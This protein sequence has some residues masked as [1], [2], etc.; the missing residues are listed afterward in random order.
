MNATFVLIL[1]LVI[2]C[3]FILVIATVIVSN[4][5]LH[6]KPLLP[7]ACAGSENPCTSKKVCIT[8]LNWNDLPLEQIDE[9]DK[10]EKYQKFIISGYSMLLGGIQ[11]N[12]IVFVEPIKKIDDIEFPAI[13]VLKREPIAIKKA[14]QV[15]D[16]AEYKVRRTWKYCRLDQQDEVIVDVVKGII[17][18]SRFQQLKNKDTNKFPEES[19]LVNDFEKRLRRYREEHEG[20]DNSSN[21]N[22]IALIS[23]TLDTQKNKVHFSIHSRNTLVGPVRHAYGVANA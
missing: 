23:T 3:L 7:V 8:D 9:Q 10:T 21:A 18:G 16:K 12:D 2:I 15:D 11:N 20:C 1:S 6:K 17:E 19:A 22:Y 4:N 5:I 13:V 14:L